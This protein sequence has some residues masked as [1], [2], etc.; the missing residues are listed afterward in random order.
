M[1]DVL[2]LVLVD[3]SLRSRHIGAAHFA[4]LLSCLYGLTVPLFQA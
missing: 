3:R 4:H 2:L 1:A